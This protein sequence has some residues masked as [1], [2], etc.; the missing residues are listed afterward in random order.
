LATTVVA[1]AACTDAPSRKRLFLEPCSAAAECETG[2]CH[3]GACSK[4]CAAST[5]CGVAFCV[6]GTCVQPERLACSTDSSCVTDLKPGPC[7]RAACTAGHCALSLAGTATCTGSDACR[8][9]ACKGLTC[10]D[11]GPRTCDDGIA[12]TT[13]TCTAP[14]GCISTPDVKTCDDNDPCTTDTCTAQGCQHATAAANTACDDANS[15]TVG[16]FCTAGKCGNGQAKCADGNACTNDVCTGGT[17]TFPANTV[18]CDDG[19][20]CTGPDLCAG[21]ACKGGAALLWQTS[22]TFKA[23]GAS[24][25]P[26][27]PGFANAAV[28]ANSALVVVGDTAPGVED[29]NA[30]VSVLDLQGNA[31]AQTLIAKSGHHEAVAAVPAGAKFFVFTI[32][33]GGASWY[34]VDGKGVPSGAVAVFDK[35]QPQFFRGAAKWAQG[36]FVAV[37][38]KTI[39]KQFDT[40]IAFGSDTGQV[41]NDTQA[42]VQATSPDGARAV[43]A[44][45]AGG[46]VVGDTY[47]PGQA[48]KGFALGLDATGKPKWQKLSP[49]AANVSESYEAA[50]AAPGGGWIVCGSESV[51]TQDHAKLVRYDDAGAV[52]WSQSLFAGFESSPC[53]AVQSVGSSIYAAGHVVQP[54]GQRAPWFARVDGFGNTQWSMI[55]PALDGFAVRDLVSDGSAIYWLAGTSDDGYP[56]NQTRI[57]RANGLGFLTCMA[58]GP[59]TIKG[60]SDCFDGKACT[61]DQCDAK[62]GLCA[63][64]FAAPGAKC[65]TGP[66]LCSGS[67][68]CL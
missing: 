63:F 13:D 45:A 57:G 8:L 21:G 46:I 32:A 55:D 16:E 17:C 23:T 12:C 62:T 59:C 48:P 29:S 42:V 26:N 7:Q 66:Q 64:P 27:G 24:Q 20:P 54:G 56:A 36:G 6:A 15:C 30:T 43:A 53:H 10:T 50:D 49:G 58:A 68:V 11:Q 33:E 14:T 38:S 47:P 18:A 40:W 65:S 19:D 9:Y 41:L 51:K 35:Q 39:G 3:L 25:N 4:A 2:L 52:Q 61:L 31:V 5:D 37:G 34:A 1:S 67:G 22:V 44:T 28:L 60:A